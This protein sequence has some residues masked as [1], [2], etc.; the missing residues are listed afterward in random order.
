MTT[1]QLLFFVGLPGLVTALGVLLAEAFVARSNMELAAEVAANPQ[2]W[3]EEQPKNV[4]ELV[5]DVAGFA[6]SQAV[7]PSV[8]MVTITAAEAKAFREVLIRRVVEKLYRLHADTLIAALRKSY[9]NEFAKGISGDE[10]LRDVLSRLDQLSLIRLL[11]G[12]QVGGIL[13]S[14]SETAA[15]RD[16]EEGH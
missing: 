13:G 3:A 4:D 11:Q 5:G 14:H 1:T 8:E 16:Q 12:E 9:G 10:K 7:G 6:E 15:F 2:R